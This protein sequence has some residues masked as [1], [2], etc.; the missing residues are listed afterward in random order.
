MLFDSVILLSS[1]AGRMDF[2]NLAI[3]VQSIEMSQM[4]ENILQAI[5]VGDVQRLTVI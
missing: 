1:S 3:F 2:N 5:H 4:S